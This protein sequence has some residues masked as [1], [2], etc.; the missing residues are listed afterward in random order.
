VIE[1]YAITDHPTPPLPPVKGLRAL[2]VDG[3]AAV[4]APGAER[5]T[6]DVSPEALWRH[7]EVVEALMADRDLLPVRYGS[8][9]PDEAALVR[10]VEVRQDELRAALGQVRGAVE[11]SLRVITGDEAGAPDAG[12]ETAGDADRNSGTF[13]QAGDG[14]RR[15]GEGARYLRARARSGAAREAIVA[16]VERPLAAL[17]RATVKGRPGSPPELLRS[18][19][20]VDRKRIDLFTRA[21]ARLQ[22][23]HPELRLL[24]TGPWPPYS[25]AER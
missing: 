18:A 19:Y 1:V 14:A 20:L 2:P 3:L 5:G 7:E 4:C 17:A 16:T 24:C 21:V 13:W 15:P 25:F 8:R 22:E 9:L 23:T 6:D 12:A 11:L 10:A